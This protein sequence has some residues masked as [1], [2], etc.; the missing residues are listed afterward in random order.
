MSSEI[1]DRCK[2]PSEACP[3]KWRIGLLGESFGSSE[4]S[5]KHGGCP[6]IAPNL[7][8]WMLCD[9]IWLFLDLYD[10][11]ICLPRTS[12]PNTRIDE[13]KR[14]QDPGR[15]GFRIRDMIQVHA[16]TVAPAVQ[17]TRMLISQARQIQWRIKHVTRHII[18]PSIRSKLSENWPSWYTCVTMACRYSNKLWQQ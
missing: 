17:I 6:L 8:Q 13:R 11:E 3:N 18:I 10:I 14:G 7:L 4:S 16:G 15:I 5:L 12:K 9:I 2:C 1:M